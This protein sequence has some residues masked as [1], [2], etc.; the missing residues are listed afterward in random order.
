MSGTTQDE[1]RG[2][3]RIYRG[4]MV[5]VAF[6]S[7]RHYLARQGGA[8]GG[9]LTDECCASQIPALGIRDDP[10]HHS[11]LGEYLDAGKPRQSAHPSC[12]RHAGLGGLLCPQRPWA[13]RN[14]PSGGRQRSHDP[15]QTH[16][17]R[18]VEVLTKSSPRPRSDAD[19][20]HQAPPEA[21][22]FRGGSPRK[23]RVDW[24]S[25]HSNAFGF[26]KPWLGERAP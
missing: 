5:R 7:S 13:G 14:R 12:G 1:K 4:V 3:T 23:D 16:D 11:A 15:R 17:V 9:R 10:S 26:C 24:P 6:D 21:G 25:C 19:R 22:G 18:R 2:R 20:G 8:G